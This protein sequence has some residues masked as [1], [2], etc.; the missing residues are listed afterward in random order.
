MRTIALPILCT[1]LG[2]FQRRAFLHFEVLALRQ[3]LAIVNQT[4][5]KQLRY[6][7]GQRLFWVW[8]WLYRLWPGLNFVIDYNDRS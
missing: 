1:L 7:W 3:Q 8:V 2:L 6:H 5:R 4:P